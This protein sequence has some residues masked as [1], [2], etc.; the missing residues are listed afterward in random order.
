MLALN[1]QS[2]FEERAPLRQAFL[3]RH[4][5]QGYRET[6]IAQDWASRRYFRIENDGK[7]YVLME[8]IP[9]HTGAYT[10][11]HKVSDYI[12]INAALYTN[13]IR[14]PQIFVADEQEGFILLEDFGNLNL[15]DA[16]NQPGAGTMSLYAKA[17]DTI[18]AFQRGMEGMKTEL[19]FYKQ[20]HIHKARQRIVDWYIPATRKARNPDGL[21]ESYLAV[22]D[23]IEKQM[24]QGSEGIAFV[25][26]DYQAENL[27]LLSGGS[28]GLLDFQGAM[29]GPPSYDL[30]NILEDIRRDIPDDVRRAML[31]RF[32]KDDPYPE[33]FHRWYRIRATQFHCRIIGQV[34]RLAIVGRRD[35]MMVFMPRVQDYIREAL[36]DPVLAPLASWMAAEKVDLAATDF[37]LEETASF[38]RD[39]AF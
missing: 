28:I 1:A 33:T 17:V 15:S 18:T 27:M 2:Y 37:N 5:G 16:L 21:V 34:L 19:P 13:N 25:H 6:L 3:E 23:E 31:D 22:W 12:L 30:A 9:D 29:W 20:G 4:A 39:D 38:I 14:V 10:P 7:I 26:G 35:R 36:K 11:G 8:A 32:A 24:P